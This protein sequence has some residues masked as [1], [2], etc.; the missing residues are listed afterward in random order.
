MKTKQQQEALEYFRK[1]AED[2]KAK[3]DGLKVAVVNVI[4]QRNGFVAQVASEQPSTRRFLDLGCGTGELVC[5]LARLGIDST[6]VDYAQEMIDLALAKANTDGTNKAGFVC[7]SMFDFEMANESYDLI[8]ANGL[9]EY[10][11]YDEL[12][13]L[14]DRVAD[15]LAPG[16][17]FVVGS[18]NRLFNL[19]TF[20]E[21]T[22]QEL[23]GSNYEL[24]VREAVAWTTGRDLQSREPLDCADPQPPATEHALTG[25]D[26]ATRFQFTPLQLIK[27]LETRGL[28][29]VEIYPIHVHGVTPAFAAANAELH[30]SIATMLQAYARGN[31]SLLAHASSFMLHVRKVR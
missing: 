15:A 25:I 27:L 18:R 12:N 22:A 5:Q 9:I 21:F 10:I 3:A 14:F 17:S 6:G 24:L 11:S 2:W 28:Q 7:R 23:S 4:E 8:S 16:G 19:V 13:L 1:N 26:V 20:N 29:A 30:A 31:M